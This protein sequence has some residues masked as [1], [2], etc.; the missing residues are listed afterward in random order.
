[1]RSVAAIPAPAGSAYDHVRALTKER[2]VILD[3]RA[4]TGRAPSR[5]RPTRSDL[6]RSYVR[7]G[8]DVITVTGWEPA[9][10]AAVNWMEAAR[11]EV[12]LAREARGADAA[13]ALAI[14]ADLLGQDAPETIG[15]VSRALASR[16]RPTSSWWRR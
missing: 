13:V 6:H 11:R 8:A 10:R 15:L 1:M 4:P 14:D 7:A 16:S 3:G 2:C 12:R 5:T 9:P